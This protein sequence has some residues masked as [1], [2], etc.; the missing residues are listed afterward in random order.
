M[1]SGQLPPGPAGA[2]ETHGEIVEFLTAVREFRDSLFP[3]LKDDACNSLAR[4]HEM[5]VA[6]TAPMLGEITTIMSGAK[7]AL[8]KAE[9][10]VARDLLAQ[11]DHAHSIAYAVGVPSATPEQVV[12]GLETGDFL[13][14]LGLDTL[15]FPDQYVGM[16][17]MGHPP[18]EPDPPSTTPIT[19]DEL[20]Y[21]CVVVES[22]GEAPEGFEVHRYLSD[23]RLIACPP[24]RR[25]GIPPQPRPVPVP[26]PEPA[27]LPRT[28]INDNRVTINQGDTSIGGGG[29]VPPPPE[30][31]PEPEPGPEPRPVPPQPVPVPPPIP[32]APVQV[33]S[34]PAFSYFAE[35]NK[36]RAD[37]GLGPIDEKQL[38]RD[39][40]AGVLPI[41]WGAPDIADRLDVYEQIMRTTPQV[42]IDALNKLKDS[43]IAAYSMTASN[44]RKMETD[45]APLVNVVNPV[46]FIASQIRNALISLPANF[47]SIVV[48]KMMTLVTRAADVMRDLSFNP[49]CNYEIIAP[50]IS[51][52]IIVGVV[53][54]YASASLGTYMQALDYTISYFCQ[55]RIPTQ[56]EVNALRM[57]GVINRRTWEAL[58][59]GNGSYTHW[60]SLIL[61]ASRT[62]PNVMEAVELYKRGHIDFTELGDRLTRLGVMDAK[63]AASFV[64]LGQATPGPQDVITFM[65]RDVADKKIVERFNLDEE[66]GDK[67]APPLTE[68]ARAAGVSADLAKLYWRAHW[69]LPSPTQLSEML[70]RLRPGAVDKDVETTV[71][72][73]ETA[74]KQDDVLPFWVKRYMAISYRPMNRTDTL[75]GFR[76]GAF[77]EKE[78]KDAFLNEGYNESDADKLVRLALSQ[79]AAFRARQYGKPNA[80]TLTDRYVRYE[81]GDVDF[82]AQMKE[83]GLTEK[84]VADAAKW[85]QRK[86]NARE[87]AA[88]ISCLHKRFDK[89]LVDNASATTLL[90]QSGVDA[91]EADRI[92]KSWCRIQ[93][94]KGKELTAAQLEQ[95]FMRGVI[96]TNNYAL[97]LA[98]IGYTI[99]EAQALVEL[100]GAK[101]AEAQVKAAEKAKA[102]AEKA[103][104]EAE[105]ARKEAEKAAKSSETPPTNG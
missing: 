61:E 6:I 78:V 82:V 69:R 58:T 20:A 17:I 41:D 30:P 14:S 9:S 79:R 95:M 8:A 22:L 47:S 26:V 23:G 76:L 83:L 62:Q 39:V 25:I 1:N 36:I 21:G 97:A 71:D 15:E 68:Y 7:K 24:S 40:Q 86:R 3:I 92:V 81:I 105:K 46:S 60:Q 103:K 88:K 49:T 91:N 73:I 31:E 33:P 32:A 90:I 93:T 2:S 18:G 55:T 63:D 5:Y 85:A 87:I 37:M 77:T 96:S 101:L 104:K 66:F 53:E 54:K 94:F 89:G 16:P 28:I 67:F 102:A 19:D 42:V 72:D 75:A 45:D 74:L 84:E 48:G 80:R 50:L 12:Y 27:P 70:H 51:T 44:L 4:A 98:R 35:L 10:R 59:K 52:R 43:L 34:A 57:S 99:P 56:A 100:S 64:A 13:G 29:G 65:T 11:V 38:L